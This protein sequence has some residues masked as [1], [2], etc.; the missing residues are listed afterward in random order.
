MNVSLTFL[1]KLHSS[2]SEAIESISSVD[3][4]KR[5]QVHEDS[6]GKEDRMALG[7]LR[8]LLLEKIKEKTRKQLVSSVSN[9][10]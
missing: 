6:M 5:D 7:E 2:L 9:K 1:Q 8:V 3:K 10:E 4:L